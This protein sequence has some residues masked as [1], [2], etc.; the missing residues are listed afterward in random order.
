MKMRIYKKK[1]NQKNKIIF[2]ITFFSIF[3]MTI[4]YSAFNAKLLSGEFITTVKPEKVVR[5]NNFAYSNAES[6]GNAENVDYDIDSVYANIKL[7][8]ANSTI[9]FDVT[10]KNYGNTELGISEY[11]LPD[12]LKDILDISFEG[13]VIGTKIRDNYD[14][15]ESSLNG[16]TKT[17]ERTFKIIVKYK[18]NAYN[19]ENVYFY[20]FY[21][22]FR[23]MDSYEI[24]YS[25]FTIMKPTIEMKSILHGN[26]YSY[27]IGVYD[28]LTV[29]MG[30]ITLNKDTD[31][32]IDNNNL[33]TI[34]N[35]S[36]NLE[37]II[38]EKN[39]TININAISHYNSA[40]LSDASFEYTLNGESKSSTGNINISV[41]HGSTFNITKISGYGLTDTNK[42]Y[43]TV[44]GNITESIVVHQMFYLTLNISP[45]NSS[46]TLNGTKYSV[47]NNLKVAYEPGTTVT[48]TIAKDAYIPQSV[49][50]TMNGHKESN[51]TLVQ[52]YTLKI[53]CT[54]ND[55]SISITYDGKT[56]S[57]S[58]GA[59]IQLPINTTG[60]ITASK[61]GYR[62]ETVNFSKDNNNIS[63][64]LLK[65][66]T[67][68]INASA[69]GAQVG[70]GD[71]TNLI[72][73]N[74]TDHTK[75]GSGSSSNSIQVLAGET[76]TYTVSARYFQTQSSN[77]SITTNE[78][79][80]Y[81]IVL[82]QNTLTPCSTDPSSTEGENVNDPDQGLHGV[83]NKTWHADRNLSS[84]A[85]A[86]TWVF[87]GTSCN[88]IPSDSRIYNFVMKYRID[89]NS[90]PT[91]TA[92][93]TVGGAA[94][95]ST[96]SEQYTNSGSTEYNFT[97]SPSAA[98]IR[99]GM[100]IRVGF[101][102]GNVFQIAYWYGATVEF[103]YVAP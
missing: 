40:V 86:L 30:G 47:K 76:I 18:E 62:T 78:D 28:T 59:S 80:T 27:N 33:L 7:P 25:G 102:K 8:N 70:A 49:S 41:P 77:G 32:T 55:A 103:N 60:T 57:S 92:N 19:A 96:R 43:N 29:K 23:F 2:I 63:I 75:T 22:D 79:K 88:N 69:N 68:T 53:N 13:Y 67:V 54:P 16:C 93:G 81:N 73:H 94:C 83:S 45:E 36:E 5:V 52:A 20:N 89:A 100:R 12:N 46:V 91:F 31:Y 84:G 58:H 15:C 61:S 97:C 95:G 85:C 42:N 3:F 74:G 21:L 71:I 24:S 72:T 65:I 4:G 11:T 51:V 38:K 35:V 90:K 98:Q 44:T 17:I 9:T 39:Y 34:P 50:F 82:S 99:N 26:T 48:G 56:Y 64:G 10:V 6:D 37:I 87:S 101:N 66:Y 14:T 1:K